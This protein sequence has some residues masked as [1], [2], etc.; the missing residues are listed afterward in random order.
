MLPSL[1]LSLSLVRK[2]TG[3]S[4]HVK[5]HITVSKTH[6]S[7]KTH[8]KKGKRSQAVTESYFAQSLV[9]QEPS[10]WNVH[11]ESFATRF[12][13]HASSQTGIGSGAASAAAAAGAGRAFR[14]AFA[15]A[16]ASPP[17]GAAPAACT[18]LLH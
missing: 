11:V 1:H 13:C 10:S 17:P 16:A 9:L 8:T 5:G 18:S 14:L 4:P 6:E 3:Q 2:Q 15:L 12:Q 7:S